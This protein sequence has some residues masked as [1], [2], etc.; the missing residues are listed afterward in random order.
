MLGRIHPLR[1]RVQEVSLLSGLAMSV[2]RGAYPVGKGSGGP[3][4]PPTSQEVSCVGASTG[5]V[6]GIHPAERLLDMEGNKEDVEFHHQWFETIKIYSLA[7][8]KC[9]CTICPSMI[10]T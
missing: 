3:I 6:L 8:C 5:K 4:P 10:T 9:H 2:V 1:S 7:S